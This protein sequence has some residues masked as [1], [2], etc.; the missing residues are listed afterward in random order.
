MNLFFVVFRLFF[1]LPNSMSKLIHNRCTCKLI[2]KTTAAYEYAIASVF[3][4]FS[5]LFC[6]PLCSALKIML[7]QL[8]AEGEVIIGEYSP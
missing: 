7:K 6:S 8:F 3:L 1:L 5:P 4:C 2:I